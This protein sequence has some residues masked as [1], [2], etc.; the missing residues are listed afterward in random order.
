MLGSPGLAY[1]RGLICAASIRQGFDVN[2]F[3]ISCAGY[4]RML[5]DR[6]S[7]LC[8]FRP[9][10]VLWVM[11]A[12]FVS[13]TEGSARR[14][15]SA[16]RPAKEQLGATLIQNIVLPALFSACD[17]QVESSARA[18]SSTVEAIEGRLCSFL[19]R[20]R[21]ELPSPMQSRTEILIKEHVPPIWLRRKP[22]S[23][24]TFLHSHPAACAIAA[25]LG[26]DYSCL[27][28]DVNHHPGMEDRDIP[29]FLRSWRSTARHYPDSF[30]FV[31]SDPFTSDK[32]RRPQ[33]PNRQLRE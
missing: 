21:L 28:V 18:Q 9:N 4:Q 26:L 23:A 24:W 14:T 27:V 17:R 8:L 25:L 1:L 12:T 16:S 2:L 33:A 20:E 19:A 11:D 10:V 30:L 29:S 5:A 7:D 13:E 31:D 15:H 6:S 22:Q 32:L 3:S